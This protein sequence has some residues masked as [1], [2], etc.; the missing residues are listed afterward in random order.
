MDILGHSTSVAGSV[1]LVDDDPRIRDLLAD[2]LT[3]HG[4]HARTAADAPAMD[5]ILADTPEIDVVILD[6]MMPGEDGLSICRRLA[7]RRGPAIIMHS[8]MGDETDRVVGLEL[9]ADAYL[10]K[11]CSPRELLAQVRAVLRRQREPSVARAQSHAPY[12]FDGW[13]LDPIGRNLTAPDK[14]VIPLANREFLLLKT[15]LDTPQVVLSREQL[16]EAMQGTGD[17]DG[18]SI[19]VQISRVRRKLGD[20]AETMIRTFRKVGYMFMPKV[21]RG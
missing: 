20:G 15:F 8:A 14:V 13:R 9:G 3:S 16:A 4:Y 12:A 18:R 7:D 5:R 21:E 2:F 11:P 1:L 19:D 6:V 10:S 17:A